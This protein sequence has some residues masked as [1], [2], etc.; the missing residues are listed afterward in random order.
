MYLA[1]LVK[2]I[3]FRK[4]SRPFLSTLKEEINKINKQKNMIIPADKTSNS[5]LVP[6][7]QYKKLLEKETQKDYKRETGIN[8]EKV[9]A[10]HRKSVVDLELAD[11]VMNTVP[12][13]AFLYLKDHKENFQNNPQSRLLN[14]TKP[15]IG[16]IAR[17]ILDNIVKT[18]RDKE[19]FTQ[20]TNTSDVIN[21]FK[22]INDKKRM[23][24]IQFDIV[25]FYPSIS[26]TLL[27]NALS[28]ATKIVEITPEQRKI[29][30]QARKSFL[31]VGEEG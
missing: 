7:P 31:Y 4:R 5:Y 9:N 28:W 2:N 6:A 11:R 26:P 8:V 16:K 14:P 10:E 23:K 1:D 15:E 27:D 3:K 30:L 24:F 13:N 29:I 25:S 21:W 18:I 17:R 19:K 22:N 12:R 20:W